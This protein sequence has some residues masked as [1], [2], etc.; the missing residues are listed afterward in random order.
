MNLEAVKTCFMLL[1]ADL[2]EAAQQKKNHQLQS[3]V[4]NAATWR[5]FQWSANR[6]LIYTQVFKLI[7]KGTGEVFQCCVHGRKT[8]NKWCN[9]TKD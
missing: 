4:M 7:I 3:K 5:P 9:A 2:T 8:V 6:L 1:Y